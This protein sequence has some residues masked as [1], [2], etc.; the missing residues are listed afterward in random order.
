MVF[1][2]KGETTGNNEFPTV[3]IQGRETIPILFTQAKIM[4]K[5]IT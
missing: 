5:F 4:Q 3:I 1:K 2:H